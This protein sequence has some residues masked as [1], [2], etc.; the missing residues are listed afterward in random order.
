ML[1]SCSCSCQ[2]IESGFIIANSVGIA[3]SNYI[4]TFFFLCDSV[5]ILFQTNFYQA[6]IVTIVIA[7][8][9]FKFFFVF[10]LLL[11]LIKPS[12]ARAVCR[13]DRKSGLRTVLT[14]YK[15]FCPRQGPRGKSR[16][17]QGLL[18]STKGY[19]NPQRKIGVA[20]HFSEIISLQSQ[21]KCWH[22][23]FLKKEGEDISS[24]ISFEFPFT[25]KKANTFKK[26]LKLHGK[27]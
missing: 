22:Q 7:M 24:Q 14:K 1:F 19:W 4:A 25:N 2:S 21:E 10:A 8:H 23:H 6:R 11:C 18:E 27:W 26:I 3:R 20:T 5:S 9:G 17:F 15:G 12:D 13:L 16:P